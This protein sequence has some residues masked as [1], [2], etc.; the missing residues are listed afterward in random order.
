MPPPATQRVRMAGE[1]G[2]KAAA[3]GSSQ[4]CDPLKHALAL[5]IRR[6]RNYSTLLATVPVHSTQGSARDATHGKS[7]LT[8]DRWMQGIFSTLVGD[9]FL[10]GSPGCT[11]RKSKLASRPFVKSF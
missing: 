9:V 4:R 3:G 8:D 5:K 6:E 1:S 10:R 11:N 2:D 7:K